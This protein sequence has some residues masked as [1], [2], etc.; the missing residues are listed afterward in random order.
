MINSFLARRLLITALAVCLAAPLVAGAA[1]DTVREV[2][3]QL[4]IPASTAIFD[5]ADAPKSDTEWATLRG[6]VA[7]LAEGGRLLTTGDRVRDRGEW[8]VQAQAHID[9]IARLS[10]AIEGRNFDAMLEA[11]DALAVTCENC[12]A[13]YLAK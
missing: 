9:A 8:L 12:H 2:M 7:T 11:G 13:K 10:K 3:E 6:H 5:V 1:A 4:T